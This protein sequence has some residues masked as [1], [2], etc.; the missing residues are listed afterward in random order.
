MF[1]HDDAST[2]TISDIALE[3]DGIIDVQYTEKVSRAQQNDFIFLHE[4]YKIILSTTVKKRYL[5]ANQY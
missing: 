2:Y 3:Y 4:G 5:L 1:L